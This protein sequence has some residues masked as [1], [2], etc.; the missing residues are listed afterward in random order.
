M[1]RTLPDE[2]VA[3]VTALAEDLTAWCIEGRDAPLARHERAVLAR[4]RRA[5]PRLLRAVVAA[6]T[7][8]LDPRL[9][10]QRAACP[11]CRRKVKPLQALRLGGL[12]RH[13]GHAGRP[14][15]LVLR[16]PLH[17][18]PLSVQSP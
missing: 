3:A 4:V 11:A 7:S 9:A 13:P 14:A 18:R 2:I 12:L 17:A 5:L 8:G 10:R 16:R 15:R 6:S 1:G